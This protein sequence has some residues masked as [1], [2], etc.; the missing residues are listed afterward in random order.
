MQ[1]K[2]FVYDPTL[3]DKQSSVRGI[4]RYLQILKENFPGWTYINNATM[5]QCNNDNVFINPFFNFLQKPLTLKLI[6]QKQIAVIHDLIPLKYPH[7]FPAGI[8]GSIYIL[9]NKL[10]LKNY[11]LI[12]T[13]SEAS[14]KDIIDILHIEERKIKVIYPCLPKIFTEKSKIL[15]HKSQI[16]SKSQIQN[17]KRLEFKNSDLFGTWNLEFGAFCLYVGDATWNKNLVNIAKAIKIADVSCVFV[18]KVFDQTTGVE[19]PGISAAWRRPFGSRTPT[20][21]EARQA[22]SLNHPWQKELKEFYEL[23]KDDK[24]FIFAGFV[25]DSELFKL[26]EQASVNL[27]LSRAEGFGFSYLEAANFSCPSLLSD[28]PVLKEISN[29]QALFADPNNPR[30]IAEKIKEIISNKIG[31]NKIGASAKK[32]SRFFSPEKFKKSWMSLLMGL[33]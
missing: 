15:N 22:P 18:G 10:A 24:R 1:N 20:G 2:V 28:I 17:S 5:K 31:R 32:R 12:I 29:N 27:L 6:A 7:H 33:D 8:K 4:G 13:D 14:K 11:D 3:K 23:T 16:N 25:P 21:K 19:T 9:L 26:Y 30:D